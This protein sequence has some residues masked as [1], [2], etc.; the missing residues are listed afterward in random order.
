MNIFRHQRKFEHVKNKNSWR[1][2]HMWKQ[3][4]AWNHMNSDSSCENFL[5]FAREFHTFIF[6]VLYLHVF[7]FSHPTFIIYVSLWSDNATETSTNEDV[8]KWIMPCAVMTRSTA[9]QTHI[10]KAE[11]LSGG[12]QQE[13]ETRLRVSLRRAR[14]KK[15][16]SV[17]L[18]SVKLRNK[19]R[20]KRLCI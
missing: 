8:I 20:H 12:R 16:V 4:M 2:F 17:F 7:I 10:L 13:V 5:I 19:T 1:F 11:W 14:P 3:N 18:Q 15:Q 6:N 9:T